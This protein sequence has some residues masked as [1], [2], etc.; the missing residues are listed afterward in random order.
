MYF[1]KWKKT[2]AFVIICQHWDWAGGRNLSWW[3]CIFNM[4]ADA[5]MATHSWRLHRLEIFSALLAL[6]VGNSPVTGEFPAQR[7]VTRRLACFFDLRPANRWANNRDAD[8]IALIMTS[9][10]CGTRALSWFATSASTAPLSIETT[11][12]TQKKRI[13]P[14]LYLTASRFREFWC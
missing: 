13:T 4:V 7:P 9:L 12:E 3:T 5:C 6:C 14:N 8:A 10:W 2:S 11:F 1:R